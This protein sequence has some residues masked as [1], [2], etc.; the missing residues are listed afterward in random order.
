MERNLLAGMAARFGAS[1]QAHEVDD[2]L[3]LV[4]LEREQPLIVAECKRA[5]RVGSDLRPASAHDAVLAKHLGPLGLGQE[6]PIQRAD[7][8]IDRDVTPRRLL[9]HEGR[10]VRL[11]EPVSYTHLTLPTIYSV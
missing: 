7:V 8:R 1:Q 10:R 9:A 6:V 4:A 2:R 5:D 3:E 11:G